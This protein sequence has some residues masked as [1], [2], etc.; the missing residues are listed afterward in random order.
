M[1]KTSYSIHKELH[2]YFIENKLTLA[3]VESITG[4]LFA[5][6][7]IDLPGA[8]AFFRG[9]LVPYANDVKESVLGVSTDEIELVGVVSSEVARKMAIKGQHILGAD[10]CISFTGNSGPSPMEGKPVGL[11]YICIVYKN[12]KM[13]HSVFLT[14]SRNKIRK[15]LVIIGKSLILDFLK[16]NKQLA[17]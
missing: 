4:G 17:Y 1:N 10:V 6:S 13:D 16:E 2:K 11:V 12:R 7:I 15:D 8:S 3:S 9:A 5:S 14:G